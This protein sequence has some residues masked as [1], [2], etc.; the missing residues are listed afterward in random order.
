MHNG[1]TVTPKRSM[2]S[3]GDVYGDLMLSAPDAAGFA[4][5]NYRPIEGSPLIGAALDGTTIGAL[6]PAGDVEP[7]PVDPPVPDYGWLIEALEA[8]KSLLE[9]AG[10]AVGTALMQTD[11]LIDL[12]KT[13]AG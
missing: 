11:E 3:D 2:A 13:K 8:H 6:E 7:P 4:A 1:W 12:L 5:D 9:V 10:S